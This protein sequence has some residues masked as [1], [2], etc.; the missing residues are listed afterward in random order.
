VP[1]SPRRARAPPRRLA[2]HLNAD[3]HDALAHHDVAR[4]VVLEDDGGVARLDH[5]AVAELHGLCALAA[6][7]AGDDDL[8]ALGARLH[9]KLDDAVAR[10]PHRQAAQQ[11]VLERLGLRLRRQAA[12][13]QPLGKELHR[14]LGKAEALA[15]DRRELAN[16][17]A[18]FAE[19]VLRGEARRVQRERAGWRWGRARRGWRGKKGAA[20][21]PPHLRVRRADDNLRARRRRA[22]LNAAKT[23]VGEL[24]QGRA[25]ARRV[26]GGARG[27]AVRR[28]ASAARRAG[29]WEGERTLPS[30]SLISANITPSATNLRFLDT[31]VAEAILLGGRAAA[32]RGRERR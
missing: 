18:L 13:G 27:R 20:S 22:D 26:A 10:A 11:L 21:T 6:Q 5:V 14:A 1:Q 15:D 28:G 17:P 9:D 30:S 24:L 31:R 25:V 19:H 32:R 12:V 2:A 29:R 3:A 16:A 23:R 4:G 7:L 8:H